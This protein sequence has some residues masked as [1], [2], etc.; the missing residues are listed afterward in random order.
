MSHMSHSP[1]LA[2]A[3]ADR[4]ASRA[5][6]SNQ[7]G[8]HP[9]LANT[10][11]KHINSAYQKPFQR[12][13]IEAFERLV[14]E[15]DANPPAR[16]ILDS[17]CGTGL[18]TRQLAEQ[19]PRHWVIGI[20]RSQVRLNKIYGASPD[21]CRLI[22][23]GCEDFWRLCAKA[24]LPIDHHYILYPNPYPKAEH[25]KRRW[26]GHPVF[27]TLAKLSPHTH[28]RSNWALYLEEFAKSW[29]LVTGHTHPVTP[30]Y[31]EKPLTLFERKYHLSGQ[32]LYQWSTE[33]T[34]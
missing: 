20:D 13:N 8:P 7:S 27:P 26:H 23:A 29:S 16:L 28:L 34:I 1:P 21:N 31:P 11:R 19:Y 33:Q 30:L 10:V 2:E 4:F 22:Q 24:A 17:C 9:Q 25:F 6:Q 15:L 32:P 5:I 14:A 18:S 12:H 3:A